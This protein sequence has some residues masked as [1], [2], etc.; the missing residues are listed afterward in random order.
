MPRSVARVR[1]CG[2]ISCAANTPVTG[3]SERIAVHQLEVAGQLLDA[4]DVPASLD[5][6]RDRG[7][8][9]IPSQDVDRADRRH[10]LAA[11]QRVA[12]AQQLD[13][14]GEQALQVGLD[15]VLLQPGIDA[16]LVLRV[17]QDLV[18]RDHQQV[19][20]LGVGDP[21]ELDD[22]RRGALVVDLVHGEHRG[23]AHPVE[24][25]VAQGVGVHEHAAVVLEHEQP[26]RE[27]QVR[28]EPP[29]VVDGAA[30]ND[31]THASRSSVRPIMHPTARDRASRAGSRGEA[32]RHVR[33]AV[34][35]GRAARFSGSRAAGI[36]R[37]A[38]MIRPSTI[39]R[40]LST[41]MWSPTK[42]MSGGP[43]RN[44]A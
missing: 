44:A 29:G 18:D 40:A 17:V 3:A 36:A 39:Q 24:R 13:L 38:T 31:E 19:G 35:S 15:A 41:P 7:A 34:A 6:D 1:A 14:L 2:L 23:R 22:A 12:L 10:V 4:V 26:G 9:R 21:P 42:P 25:L 16:E 28:A 33:F 5:L 20:G 11:H 27:R 30:G 43:M 8:R 32:H 37:V